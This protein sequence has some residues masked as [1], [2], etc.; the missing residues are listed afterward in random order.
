MGSHEN[1]EQTAS[2]DFRAETDA[3]ERNGIMKII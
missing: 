3:R 1:P 2:W